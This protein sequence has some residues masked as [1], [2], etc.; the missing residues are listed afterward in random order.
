LAAE[1]LLA[2][3]HDL[4]KDAASGGDQ[5]TAAAYAANLHGPI[6]AGGPRVQTTRERAKLVRRC[7]SPHAHGPA[8]PL[9]LPALEEKLVPLACAQL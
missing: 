6:E 2:C 1:R 3:W 4:H 9:G 8:R 5:G 7:D